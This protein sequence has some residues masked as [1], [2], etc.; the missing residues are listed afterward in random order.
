M[1]WMTQLRPAL[2][3]VGAM[4]EVH[5]V[6]VEGEDLALGV[7][8]FELN[9]EDRLLHLPLH[10]LLDA[11]R[12]KISRQVLRDGARAGLLALEQIVGQSDENA[13]DTQPEMLL[14]VGVFGRDDRL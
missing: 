2:A 1:R 8:A 10:G 9:G 6:A 4:A 13:G 11:D 3:P 7:T 14:E 12:R 5:L